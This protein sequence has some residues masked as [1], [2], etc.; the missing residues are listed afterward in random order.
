MFEIDKKDDE[1][2]IDW[3]FFIWL[4]DR[5]SLK[6]LEKKKS[7]MKNDIQSMDKISLRRVH[8]LIFNHLS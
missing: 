2:N 6:N 3:M 1:L 7:I 8:V 5:F 4:V